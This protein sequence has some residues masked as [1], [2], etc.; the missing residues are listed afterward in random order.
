MTPPKKGQEIVLVEQIEPWIL[1]IRGQKVILDADLAELY[2]VPTK[3]LNEQVKRNRARFPADFVFQ[4]TVEEGAAMRSPDGTGNL[5]S[6]NATSS[7]QSHGGRRY[8]P[9]AFTEHGAIMAASVLNTPRAIEVSVYVVRAFVK[10]R[11]YGAAH[12]ELAQKLAELERKVGSHDQ[13]IRSLVAT[14]REL[15]Q[16]PAATKPRQIGFHMAREK[17][18]EQR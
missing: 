18:R 7:S 1:L 2:G 8:R 11:E 13:T 14:I 10:L 5:R 9:H 3:R 17:A 16:P 15:M 6:Q 12:R 4:L